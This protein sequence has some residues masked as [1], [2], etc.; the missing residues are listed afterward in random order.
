MACAK[1]Q[2]G[3]A[4]TLEQV[5][6]G[7]PAWLLCPLSAAPRGQTCSCACCRGRDT[8]WVCVGAVSLPLL[9][10]E[11]Q[12]DMLPRHRMGLTRTM[13]PVEMSMLGCAGS[14]DQDEVLLRA[15]GL[16][17]GPS[18]NWDETLLM[19][20]VCRASGWSG[21]RVVMRCRHSSWVTERQG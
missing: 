4:L 8:Q 20:D 5:E 16:G 9:L 12:L 14:S 3:A 10:A 6:P 1:Q 18:L 17:A 7:S 2:N 13:C 19:R 15:E 11:T 21:A